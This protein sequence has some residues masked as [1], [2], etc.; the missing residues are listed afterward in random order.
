MLKNTGV[1]GMVLMVLS[2]AFS[3]QGAAQLMAYGGRQ[4]DNNCK[5][6]YLV[7]QSADSIYYIKGI[8]KSIEDCQTFLNEQC[9]QPSDDYQLI[10]WQNDG[11][12]FLLLPRDTMAYNVLIPRDKE[13][14]KKMLILSS[15]YSKKVFNTNEDKKRNRQI[16]RL[17]EAVIAIPVIE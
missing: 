12:F 16:K 15:R 1:K 3:L 4:T 13:H 8:H 9:L 17:K 6:I 10:M 7:N 14:L 5:T 11:P 2:L